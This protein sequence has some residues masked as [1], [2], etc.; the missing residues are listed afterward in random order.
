[1]RWTRRL[2]SGKQSCRQE[3]ILVYFNITQWSNCAVFKGE[4][5]AQQTE[6]QISGA[7]GITDFPSA[8]VHT[9]TFVSDCYSSFSSNLIILNFVLEKLGIQ[10]HPQAPY[11]WDRISKFHL[12]FVEFDEFDFFLEIDSSFIFYWVILIFSPNWAYR[13][14]LSQNWNLWPRQQ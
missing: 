2:M 10:S 5:L 9:S 11:N 7:N 13:A 1:M 4:F 12:E 14:T 3:T 6:G 8:S